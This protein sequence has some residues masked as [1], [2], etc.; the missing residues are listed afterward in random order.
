METRFLGKRCLKK[1]ACI[2][3]DFGSLLEQIRQRR[4][5]E[6]FAKTLLNFM[7]NFVGQFVTC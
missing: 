7:D 4:D 2:G 6:F 1:K 5:A 3:I